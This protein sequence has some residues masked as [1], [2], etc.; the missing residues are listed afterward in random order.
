MN[1]RQVQATLRE[2]DR[3]KR[4]MQL[5]L[6][7]LVIWAVV[8]GWIV[9]GIINS[10]DGDRVSVWSWLAYVVPTLALGVGAVAWWSR[11]RRTDRDLRAE[12]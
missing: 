7:L 9:W 11:W 5:W 8:V 1:E 4:A 6:A 2:R 10:I 12:V 3:A